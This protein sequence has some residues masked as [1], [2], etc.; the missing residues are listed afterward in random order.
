MSKRRHRRIIKRLET[1]F[2]ANGLAF[3]GVSSD[4]S[5]SGLFVR[6]NKPFPPDTLVDLTIHLPGDKVSRL[7]GTVRRAVKT[8]TTTMKNGMGMEIVEIDHNYVNFLNTMLPAEEQVH[9]IE[10][11]NPEAVPPKAKTESAVR[12]GPRPD[13]KDDPIDSMISALFS[14]RDNS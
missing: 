11:S 8:G 4:L 6:T 10:L 7:K 1:E 14:K 3:R 9:D 13:S 12:P 2:S 5:G